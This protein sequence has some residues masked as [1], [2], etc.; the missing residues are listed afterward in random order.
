MSFKNDALVYF[1][2]LGNIY[3]VCDF[4]GRPSYLVYFFFIEVYL[5]RVTIRLI[6]DF[7]IDSYHKNETS[8]IRSRVLT[9]IDRHGSPYIRSLI[10]TN[11]I[12][13]GPP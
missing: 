11:S 8:Y 3:T 7:C 2:S 13:D 12:T 9:I 6:L 5:K 1:G 10:L 4:L